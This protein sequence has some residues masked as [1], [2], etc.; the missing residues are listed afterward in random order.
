MIVME[1][2]LLAQCCSSPSV[3]QTKNLTFARAYKLIEHSV[4]L[5]LCNVKS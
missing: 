3:V 2:S 1:D 4:N 5:S